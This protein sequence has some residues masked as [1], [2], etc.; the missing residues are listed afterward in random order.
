MSVA[1]KS[2]SYTS[3]NICFDVTVRVHS[4]A[5][6]TSPRSDSGMIAGGLPVQGARP[7]PKASALS[8]RAQSHSSV[9]ITPTRPRSLVS[10]MDEKHPRARFQPHTS[11]HHGGRGR[12][13]LTRAG[14]RAHAQ[15]GGA[16]RWGSPLFLA[17]NIHVFIRRPPSGRPLPRA[18]RRRSRSRSL[19]RAP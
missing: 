6:C 1:V 13:P 19:G 11:S 8:S 16:A 17:Y 7:Q 4:P 12:Q 9:F 2:T 18:S 14:T 15:E 5:R 3:S 10:P